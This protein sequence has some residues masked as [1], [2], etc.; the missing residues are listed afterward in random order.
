VE[1][2][3]G[4]R[5]IPRVG[6]G[7]ER[8]IPSRKLANHAKDKGGKGAGPCILHDRVPSTHLLTLTTS[9]GAFLTMVDMAKSKRKSFYGVRI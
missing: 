8:E 2:R 4:P 9:S 3:D 5:H 1:A 7:D 6:L